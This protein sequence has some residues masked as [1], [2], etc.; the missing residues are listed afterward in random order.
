MFLSCDHKKLRV[1]S[2]EEEE[3]EEEEEKEIVRNGWRTQGGVGAG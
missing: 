1:E 2:E 3:E